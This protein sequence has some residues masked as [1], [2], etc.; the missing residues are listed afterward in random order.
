MQR[1]IALPDFVLGRAKRVCNIV[2]WL[3]FG[4]GILCD[5]RLVGIKIGSMRFI[6]Q[7]VLEFTKT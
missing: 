5:G 1:N 7:T 4:D 3:V 6:R 2:H